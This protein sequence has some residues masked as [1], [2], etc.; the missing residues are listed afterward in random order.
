VAVAAGSVVVVAVAAVIYLCISFLEGPLILLHV[1][2][3][4]H[5]ETMFLIVDVETK[6]VAKLEGV[7]MI[8]LNGI[9]DT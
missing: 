9:S 7:C 2:Q 3:K 1:T 8:Y 5:T 6:V 4:F